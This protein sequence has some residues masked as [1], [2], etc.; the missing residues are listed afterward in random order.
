MFLPVQ[1]EM[2]VVVLD[3]PF[4]DEANQKGRTITPCLW[5][6]GAGRAGC[7]W[8]MAEAHG[9][10]LHRAIPGVTSSLSPH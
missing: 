1:L 8:Q 10:S 9:L 3:I 7:L 5:R 2:G 4:S 6:G